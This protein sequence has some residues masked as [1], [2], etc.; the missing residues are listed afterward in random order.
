MDLSLYIPGQT[1]LHKL[2]A[3]VKFLVLLVVS[4]LAYWVEGLAVFFLAFLG[5]LGL[6]AYVNILKK[7]HRKVIVF[8]LVMV[9]LFSIFSAF[10]VDPHQGLV[11]FFRL[12]SLVMLAA[13]VTVTTKSDAFIAMIERTLLPLSIFPFIKP[14]A[15]SLTISLTLRFIPT[16]F[17]LGMDIREAQAA[18]GLQSNPIALIVPLIVLTLKHA[19]DVSDAL[20]ARMIE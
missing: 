19:D 2:P 8:P 12:S 3:W 7:R 20:D 14:K 11:T 17:K 15:I 18:R 10:V 5:A 16:I 6:V 9:I 1:I 4:I 13:C